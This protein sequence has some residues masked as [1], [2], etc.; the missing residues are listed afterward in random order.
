M[1]ASSHEGHDHDHDHDHDHGPAISRAICVL[2][3]TEGNSTAGVI[4]FTK[5]DKG[6]LIEGTISG[7][8]PNGKH[9]FHIHQYGDLSSADGT[10]AGGHFNPHGA[11]HAGPDDEHR[12]VGDLG[13]VEADAQGNAT[14]KRVDSHITFE[15]A[16]SIIGRGM[17][18]H[19]GTD[20]LKT[21]PTGDAGGRIAQGVIGIAA[22]E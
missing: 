18:L 17:I 1:T 7:L 12:H 22:D 14:Y 15:G 19:A 4:T 13:N 9:G 10:K 16:T 3:P 5:T 2:S 21:Q 20:D 8:T 11:D 6:V